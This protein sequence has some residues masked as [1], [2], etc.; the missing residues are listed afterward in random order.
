MGWGAAIGG[1]ASIAGSALGG[2]GG[3]EGGGEGGEEGMEIVEEFEEEAQGF[4]DTMLRNAIPY[5]EFFTQKA[6][7]EMNAKFDQARNDTRE[8]YERSLAFTAPYRE[9]GYQALDTLQDTLGIARPGSGSS[10]MAHAQENKA[11]EQAIRRSMAT[12]AANTAS[13][14]GMPAEDRYKFIQAAQHGSN[15]LG[16]QRA[17][18]Q[19]ELQ[20]GGNRVDNTLRATVA[21]AGEGEEPG[22][23]DYS[24]LLEATSNRFNSSDPRADF[25]NRAMPLN[26]DLMR[27]INSQSSAQRALANTANTGYSHIKPAKKDVY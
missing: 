15:L 2:S 10:A 20:G 4:L 13:Q 7:D 23:N 3:G 27:M 6:V 25:M 21:P 22:T 8:Y 12:Q 18:Q 14:M 17:L 5:S 9:A 1:I 26:S 16:L 24:N 11:K 19:Y